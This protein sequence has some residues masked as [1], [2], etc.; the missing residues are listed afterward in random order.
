MELSITKPDD[1]H[2]HLRDGDLLEAVVSHRLLKDNFRVG[3][4]LYYIFQLGKI[5]W[6]NWFSSLNGYEYW[7][8]HN[9][10]T[11]HVILEGQ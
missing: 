4:T 10:C 2:L 9:L 5:V 8:F 1:W 3:F 11:V 6:Q 7:F